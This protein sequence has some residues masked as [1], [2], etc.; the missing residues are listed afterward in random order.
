MKYIS[1]PSNP[2]IKQ[3]LDLEKPRERRLQGIFVIEGIRELSQAIKAGYEIQ[4]IVY[5][6]ELIDWNSLCAKLAWESP[7]DVERIE[8]SIPVYNKVAYRKDQAGV[9][10]LAKPKSHKLQDLRLREKPLILVLESVEKPG[11]LGALLRTADAAN[12]DAL[13]VCDPQTDIYNPNVIRSSLGGVF[14]RQV[15]VCTTD[16]AVAWL[17]KHA[18]RSFATALTAHEYYHLVDYGEAS[19][20]VMGSEAYGL[21][22][23]WL[24]KADTLIKIPMLG[25]VDSM[26]VSVSAAIV[27]FEA[28]RRRNFGL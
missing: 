13:I 5:A 12:L 10:A 6:P 11:N 23:T 28:L 17:H 14:I 9:I 26:N 18:I 1:S 4:T 8:T 7:A 25:S 24:Q 2:L 16:E 22:E 20:I 21:S 15:A 27:V 3:I 19:A